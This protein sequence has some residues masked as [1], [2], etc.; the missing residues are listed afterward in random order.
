MLLIK[1]DFTKAKWPTKVQ[2]KSNMQNTTK[3]RTKTLV[4]ITMPS[5]KFCNSLAQA[6]TSNYMNKESTPS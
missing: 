2:G 6:P 4:A 3:C 1:Q 5:V